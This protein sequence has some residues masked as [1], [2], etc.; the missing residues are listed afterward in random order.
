MRWHKKLL[1]NSTIQSCL[2]YL[3]KSYQDLVL[4]S[5]SWKIEVHPSVTA[6][7]AEGKPMILACWHQRLLIDPLLWHCKSGR[8]L[9]HMMISQHRDGALMSRVLELHGARSISGSSKRGGAAA[10]KQSVAALKRGAVVAITPDGPR[11]PNRQAAPGIVQMAR[12]TGAAIVPVSSATTNRKVFSSW[13]RMILP[14]PFGKGRAIWDAPFYVDRS[15]DDTAREATRLALQTR[16]SE[17]CDQVDRSLNLP[18][19]T[20]IVKTKASSCG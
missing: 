5:I 2:A 8:P 18:L 13:D 1:S 20:A 9:G 3:V 19:N 10:L 11:G 6:L 4:W 16:L 15:S 17:L 7:I 14:L 12:L